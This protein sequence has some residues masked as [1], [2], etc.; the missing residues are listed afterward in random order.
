MAVPATVSKWQDRSLQALRLRAHNHETACRMHTGG[1]QQAAVSQKL[2][3][4]PKLAPQGAASA[5]LPEDLPFA[6]QSSLQSAST[7][8]TPS[9]LSRGK[10]GDRCGPQTVS[11]IQGLMC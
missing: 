3:A 4:A 6:R 7:P 11:R 9:T 10:Q 1:T 5:P 2:E 8:R